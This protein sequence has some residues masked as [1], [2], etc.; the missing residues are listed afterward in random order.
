MRLWSLVIAPAIALLLSLLV[1][2][3]GLAPR[4]LAQEPTRLSIDAIPTDNTPTSVI[5]IDTCASAREGDV[6]DIDLVIEDVTDLL[7]WELYLSY[8]PEVLEVQDHDA[9]MFQDANQGSKVIDLSEDTPDDDG[10]YL[11]QAFDSADPDSPDSGS[12][13]LARVTIKAQ[14]PGVSPLRISKTD[15]ND[16][17]TPD[18]GPILRD[19]AGDIIGDKNG[20]TLFDGP[21]KGAE[22]RVGELCADAAAK[23]AA[24]NSDNSSG[25]SAGV[26]V[27][28]ILGGLAAVALTLGLAVVLLRRRA[29]RS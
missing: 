13:V 12:G 6:F 24:Q 2:M 3:S 20:D 10:R 8:D 22:I 25:I 21:R 11:M 29:A 14:G 9:A 17:G 23:A 7:A 26:V 1:S 28:A 27:G 5:E 18:Q 16:D 4:S 15:L 19:A